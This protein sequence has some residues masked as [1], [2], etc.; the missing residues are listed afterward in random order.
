MFYQW[1]QQEEMAL[2]NHFSF[3]TKWCKKVRNTQQNNAKSI[4]NTDGNY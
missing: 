3:D 4:R 2:V 1:S